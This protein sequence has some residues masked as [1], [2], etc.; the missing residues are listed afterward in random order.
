MCVCVCVC[1]VATTPPL[2]SLPFFFVVI[3]KNE[4]IIKMSDTKASTNASFGVVY[5]RYM[6]MDTNALYRAL[7]T[8]DGVEELATVD[9]TQE[10]EETDA[11]VDGADDDDPP[12]LVSS[13]DDDS[14]DE[15]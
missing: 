14:D 10:V 4:D 3:K 8:I 11:T 1:G 15:A 12:E 2:F 13:S 5:A 7:A 9:G 6:Y